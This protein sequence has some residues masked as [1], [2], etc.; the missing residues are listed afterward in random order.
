M[1]KSLRFFGRYAILTLDRLCQQRWLLA[2]LVLLFILLPLGAGQAARFLLSQGVDFS[3]VTLAV[4]A[5]EGDPTPGQLAR[6]MGGMEDIAQYCKITAMD[7]E[8]ALSALEAGEVTA[9]LV[10]PENFIQGVMWGENPD[11]KLIVAGD[12]PLESLLLLWVGQ[13]ASDILSAFQSGVYAVL[14]LYDQSPPTGLSRDRV[15]ADIN[16]R[17]I[18]LALNREGLFEIQEISA[19][20]TLP[21]FLH[22][23]LAML[24]YFSLSAAPL[25]VPVYSGSWLGFQRRLG[26]AGRG[27]GAGYCSGLAA[28]T[29]I[30]FVPLAFGL[31]LAGEGNPLAL[32]GAALGM[33]LFSSVFCGLCCLASGSAA[34]CGMVSFGASLVCLALAGGIVPPVFLPGGVRQL[35]GLSPVT[36][37][38]RLAAWPMGCD[39]PLSAGAGLAAAGI[40]MAALSLVLYRRRAAREEGTV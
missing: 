34:G 8:E 26:C 32:L 20:G 27:I 24:A 6:Y 19:T 39:M 23:A 18:H 1:M 36:W 28:G 29:V 21:V 40:G 30:L 13:S 33:A 2:G 14:D 10:L 4:T 37:L 17:Y 7:G 35:A 15:V 9:V 5:R 11:L 31:L 38:M 16:L 3:G 12:R 25:F 22:Y